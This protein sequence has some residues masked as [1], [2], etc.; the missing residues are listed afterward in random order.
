MRNKIRASV[1]VVPD[2][3]VIRSPSLLSTYNRARKIDVWDN[4][5]LPTVNAK[6]GTRLECLQRSAHRHLQLSSIADV[7][8]ATQ[9]QVHVRRSSSATRSPFHVRPD[10]VV[11]PV[12]SSIPVNVYPINSAKPKAPAPAN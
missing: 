9:V 3:T 11:L 12:T 8:V 7:I 4:V 10:R 2:K 5:E 6:M 1:H